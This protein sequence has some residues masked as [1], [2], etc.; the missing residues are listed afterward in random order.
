MA[1]LYLDLR[2]AIRWENGPHII[3]HWRIWI[4]HFIGTGCKNYAVEAVTLHA[5]IEVNFPRHIS[6]IARHNRTVNV[7]GK[8]GQGKPID[9]LMEH[10]NL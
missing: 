9:Q 7:S 8:P 2:N 1:F 5:N 10:Y 3:R 6:Y 4:P